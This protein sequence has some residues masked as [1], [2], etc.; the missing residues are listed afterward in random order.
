MGAR[1]P[2]GVT[3]GFAN[4]SLPITMQD[5]LDSII[6]TAVEP[7]KVNTSRAP[8]GHEYHTY[9]PGLLEPLVRAVA[10]EVRDSAELRNAFI[11]AITEQIPVTA[12]MVAQQLTATIVHTRTESFGRQV[13]EIAKWAE[14]AIKEAFAEAL[15]EPVA[16][17]VRE[18]F[19]Q[20]VEVDE[21]TINVT[22][23]STT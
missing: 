14:P 21:I 19:G 23:R 12:N 7:R 8:D 17:Y 15:K 13:V 1:V 4:S 2:E 9:E 6:R 18:R 11:A 16:T 5:V 10:Q 20:G 22:M 3:V